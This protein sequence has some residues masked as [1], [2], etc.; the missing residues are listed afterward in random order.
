M[1]TVLAFSALYSIKG[2]WHWNIPGLKA[3]DHGVVGFILDGTRLSSILA[4]IYIGHHADM[5]TGLLF[6]LAWFIGVCMSM[7]EEAGAIGRWGSAW[8]PYLKWMP[9][10]TFYRVPKPLKPVLGRDV[11]PIQE[12]QL[13]G[14]KKGLQRG[15]FLGALLTLATGYTPFILAGASFPVAYFL[16]SSLTYLITKRPKSW[17]CAEPIYG[18]IIGMAGAFYPGA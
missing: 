18:A 5:Q 9:E 11:F 16:G 2:G 8:G 1:I 6:G 10:T 3:L 14:W 4:A 7:G 17:T 15:V 13:Y 12:G